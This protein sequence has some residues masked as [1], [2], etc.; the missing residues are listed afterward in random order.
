MA[1]PTVSSV[2]RAACSAGKAPPSGMETRSARH[3]LEPR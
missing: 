2:I 1:H 3:V